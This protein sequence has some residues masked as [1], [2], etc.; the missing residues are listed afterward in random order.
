MIWL[1]LAAATVVGLFIIIAVFNK[2]NNKKISKWLC[3]VGI[4]WL[5]AGSIA[6][7][8]TGHTGI[9]VTFGAVED[10]TYE[11]GVHFKFP[12][13]DVVIMDNRTQKALLE[14]KCF[15]SDIQ[16]VSVSYSINYQI[17]KENAQNIYKTI[18]TKY[19]EVVMEPRIHEAVRSVISKYSAEN[20]I[21]SRDQLSVKITDILE[22]ELGAYNIVVVNTAI[23]DLDF[24]D[25]FTNAVEEK[26][27]AQQNYLKA[28]TEQEQKTMEQEAI[29]KR[30]EI[31]A[32]AAAEVARIQAEADAEVMKIQADAAEYAGQ[33]DAA[34][35][36]AISETLTEALIKYYEIQRWDGKLPEYFVSGTEG[37]LPILGN[38]PTVTE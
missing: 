30:E 24:S 25:A 16:E 17:E 20:L 13:Q 10:T 28:Q 4:A 34:V 15:S 12:V 18:G 5:A 14:L 11:A 35:N 2:L 3:L 38:V 31:S 22:E 1:G 26:Q 37:V 36:K 27:V 23:E 19:Y 6:M 32:K 21:E 7:V 9:L 33:R 8:P 29:A